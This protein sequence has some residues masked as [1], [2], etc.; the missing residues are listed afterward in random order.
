MKVLKR[1][2]TNLFVIE[3]FVLDRQS[4]KFNFHEREFFKAFQI[5]KRNCYVSRIKFQ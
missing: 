5:F 3:V 4:N 1:A 2:I